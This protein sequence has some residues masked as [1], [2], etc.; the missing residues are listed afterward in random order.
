MV[1][2]KS[3]CIERTWTFIY[4]LQVFSF[5]A[6]SL[7]APRRPLTYDKHSIPSILSIQKPQGQKGE[8]TESQKDKKTIKR[9]QYVLIY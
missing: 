6:L 3:W 1:S 4:G 9:T 8:N 5:L 2:G 7:E